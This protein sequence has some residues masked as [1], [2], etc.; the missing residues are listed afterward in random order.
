M[1]ESVI[2]RVR[3]CT[4]CEVS[5]PETA[6]FFE[7]RK[8]KTDWLRPHCRE[9]SAA[10]ARRRY[11]K[12]EYR[13]ALLKKRGENLELKERE[14]LRQKAR[15]VDHIYA[16]REKERQ[17]RRLKDQKYREKETERNRRRRCRPQYRAKISESGKKWYAVNRIERAA[18]IKDWYEKNRDIIAARKRER[19]WRERH[20]R[21]TRD[22]LQ[23]HPHL[24]IFGNFSTAI[25]KILRDG[26]MRGGFRYLPYSK[27][28]LRHHLEKQF[29]SGMT[30]DNYGSAWH[31]DHI[32]PQS[33]F[34]I[35]TRDPA[36]CSAFQ[37]CWALTNLRPLWKH[38]NLVKSA[39]RTLL[40]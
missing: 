20:N 4:K 3:A 9:C 15:K 23:K 30:W 8:T 37:A 27:A 5:K 18:K 34:E 36:N 32:L 14:R 17:K 21:W 12:P 6:E 13:A 33:S 40:L 31:V 10:T 25:S 24:R 29:S 35:N 28:D 7:P 1:A 2:G 26:C 11:S 19:A 22:H 38:D 39:K 16:A